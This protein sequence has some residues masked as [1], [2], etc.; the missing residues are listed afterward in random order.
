MA[1][2]L[3]AFASYLGHML[4]QVAAN[5]A[6]TMLGVSVEIDKMG[7]KL[8]DLKN[9]LADA[10]RRNITDTTVQEW[11]GQLKRAMYE[12]TDIL[13]LCQLK[14]MERGPSTVNAGCFN[15][16]LFCM[17]NPILAHEIGI[18]IK[19]LNRRLDS[20]KERGA[21]F[22][23]INLRYYEAHS[24][25]AHSSRHG[26][27]NR[28]TAGDFDRA[29]MVGEKIEEDTRALVVQ[30]MQT[31]KEVNDDIRVVAIVGVGG[32]GKTTLAQKVFNDEAIQGE[33]SKKIWLSV[34]QNFTEVEL[35]RRAIIEAGGDSQSAGNAKATLHRNL[36]DS[37]IGHKTLL[38]MDDV[39]DHGAWEGVLRIPFVNAV[40]SGSRVL[41]TTRDEGVAR[42]MAARWPY[43][44]I[45][46]LLLEDAWSLL[47][48]QV[49]SSEIDEDHI[50]TLKD[51][52]LK[53]IQKCGGLP[54]AVKVMGGLL[55]ER[56]GLRRDWE[57]VLDDS[58]WSITKMP[59]E[60]NYAVYLSYEYMPSYLK[61][62]FLF[63]SILP[64][65][66]IFT[67]NQVV[68]MW[69]SE[70]FIHGNSSD[71]EELG[72]SYYKELVSRNLIE[73]DKSYIGLMVC[74]MH[75][76]VRSFAQYM[77]KDEALVAHDGDNDILTKLSSQKFLRLSIEANQS[78][79]GELDWKSLRAQQSVRTL[80]LTIQIKMNPGD[81]LVT[82]SSLRILYI[83][84][85]GVAALVE[86]L[87]QLKHLRY[88]ALLNT[89]ISVLPKNIGK[90]KLLQFFDLIGCKNLVNLPN[91]IV[92]LSQLRLLILPTSS[93]VPRG[94]SGLTNM[95]RLSGFRAH[96]DSDSCSLDELGPLS[97]LRFLT[98][99]ELENVSAAPFAANA[100]LGEKKHLIDIALNCTSKL[101]D[102]GLV[103][104]KEGVSE[105]EQR[106]IVNVFDELCPP[107]SV[108][109]L[110]IEGYF[111]QKLPSW[112]MSTS[113][114]LL[115]NLR[116]LLF[117]D[118][119]CCT[120]LPNGLCQ[121]PNLQLLQVRRAPC[122]K[123]VGTRFLQAAATP[124]PRLN[125]LTLGGMVQWEEWEWEE[126]V[127]A[128]PRLEK[129][130]LITCKLMRVPPGLASNAR[131]LKVLS[132]N[133]VQQLCC[134]ENFPFVVELTVSGSSDLERITGLPNMQKLIISGCPKLKVLERIP[135]L[136][137]LVLE[138][139]IMEQLPGYMQDINPRHLLLHCRIWLLSALAVGQSG[140][141]WDK[142][143]HVEHVKAYARDRD[144][145]RKWYLFYTRRD[146]FKLDSNTSRYTIFEETLSSSMVDAQGFEAVYKMRRSTFNHVC[147]LVRVS[148]FEDMM[149]RGHTFTFVDG[150]VL[151][152]QDCVAVALRMLNS[153]EPP[154]IVGSSVGVNESTVSL[155]TQMF[156][157][158]MWKQE[159]HNILWPRSAEMEKIKHKFDKIHGLPN[160]CGVVHT[161][162][163]MFGSQNHEPGDGEYDNML[164]LVVDPD[165]RFIDTDLGSQNQLSVLH[166]SWLFKSCQEGITLNGSKLKVSDGL[167]VG[168]YII[169]DAGYPLLPWL[170][171]PYPLEDKDLSADFPSYQAEF[172]RRHS[173]ASTLT[174][175]AVA[176]LKDTWKILDRAVSSGPNLRPTYVCCMLH[177]I[178]IDME[179]AEQGVEEGVGM[180]GEVR[181]L[182]D[183][184]A[185]RTRDVLAKHL[186]ESR[187]EEKEASVVIAPSSG[188]QNKGQGAR[189]PQTADWGKEKVHDSFSLGGEIR[190]SSALNQLGGRG[191]SL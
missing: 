36:K 7:G 70:G 65:S 47:K 82:F 84:S 73:P 115:G 127:Q 67:L 177:N 119:A 92:K 11:V 161:A 156:V 100:K 144:N 181:H 97:Q 121:L 130:T 137:R 170:L 57:H 10:D 151:C 183:E 66:K 79:S 55:R 165:M 1:M 132:F 185:A 77:T 71:L 4:T 85:V 124:F 18:R 20:I 49:L 28:E 37:I 104:E 46:T 142:F 112:I 189:R 188:D 15:P 40:S 54:L 154:E 74:S 169:G 96:M 98:L 187:E 106:R 5:K 12:A 135:K 114:V 141:E 111:G 8:Q 78:R 157:D 126:Q 29:A 120:Q 17:R 153:G 68:G 44:H 109:N 107:P 123:R 32:I 143:S 186:I 152:L 164:M 50:N 175:A 75:D 35:L 116:T 19:T 171:T 24:S 108:E 117:A 174:L 51:V 3:D 60:L 184:D 58:K 118:L 110:E 14:A 31:G 99:H 26:N 128:M 6:G 89:D 23:F 159:I 103:K 90:M 162:H 125:K 163:I 39:W 167:D 48:K 191:T 83:H 190:S 42:G 62:C 138:D 131:A 140:L 27:P 134:L 43:H 69:I 87:H 101:G 160:C 155:V 61:Q 173:A 38:V 81:S 129:L 166:D 9:F 158:A 113:T 168:E 21:S 56:G 180:E 122:I 45:D 53:I 2:V 139:Y 13:D 41:I 136:E 94:F 80:I 146:N 33:F 172:N 86:S 176:R 105:E 133:N 72:R 93:M 16:L 30:I 59:Q 64:K 22:N 25:N 52:G 76:V 149:T 102:D 63:Y 88:L 148:F 147:R 34:N 145:Q 182:A 179:K 95:R 178:V 150:K 91:S